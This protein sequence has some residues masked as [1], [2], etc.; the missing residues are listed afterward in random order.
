MLPPTFALLPDEVI[1]SILEYAD[2][3]TAIAIGQ[4][5]RRFQDVASEPLL[6]RRYCIERF[7]VWSPRHRFW[8]RIRSKEP[9]DWKSLFIER[10][11][12]DRAVLHTLDVI[13]E[14]QVGR[15]QKFESLIQIGYDAKE[16]LLRAYED[17]ENHEDF[18]ARRS[19]S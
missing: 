11:Q 19:V 14:N 4:V 9:F 8:E 10:I 12:T 5:S 16:T 17:S 2:P 13:I 15:C 1:Q 18:L 7:K 6:W 3:Q